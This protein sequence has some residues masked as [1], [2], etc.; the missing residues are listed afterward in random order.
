MRLRPL[1]LLLSR[2]R[3]SR[4]SFP[5]TFP[6]RMWRTLHGHCSRRNQSERQPDGFLNPLVPWPFAGRCWLGW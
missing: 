6:L 2:R 3:R 1:V 4:C 5:D